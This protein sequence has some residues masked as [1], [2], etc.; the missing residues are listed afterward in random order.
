MNVVGPFAIRRHSICIISRPSLAINRSMCCDIKKKIR[1]LI[2]HISISMPVKAQNVNNK[3]AFSTSLRQPYTRDVIRSVFAQS[4]RNEAGPETDGERARSVLADISVFAR[5]ALSAL[6]ARIPI[7]LILRVMNSAFR[8]PGDFSF[9]PR[10]Y[11]R[12][13]E[14]ELQVIVGGTK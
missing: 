2:V 7:S 5:L 11:V 1:L 9:G 14:L 3:Y 6:F 10:K 12:V 4:A 8:D 13:T